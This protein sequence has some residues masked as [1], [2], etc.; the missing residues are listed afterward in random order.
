MATAVGVAVEGKP[1][2]RERATAYR[3]KIIRVKVSRW[4]RVGERR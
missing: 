1:V 2:E 4:G 3:Q